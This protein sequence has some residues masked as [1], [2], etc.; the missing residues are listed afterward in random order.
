MSAD[1]VTQAVR[2]TTE[3]QFADGAV[4]LQLAFT[5]AYAYVCIDHLAAI[6]TRNSASKLDL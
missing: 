1:T 2:K 6:W 3:P 4:G 5:W